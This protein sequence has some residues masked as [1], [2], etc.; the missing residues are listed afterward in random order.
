[1]IVTYF[2]LI[3]VAFIAVLITGILIGKEMYD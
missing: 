2:I 3:C 1:M